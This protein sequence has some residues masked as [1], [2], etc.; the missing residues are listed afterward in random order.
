MVLEIVSVVE[1]YQRKIHNLKIK[2]GMKRAIEE[3]YNPEKNLKNRHLHS[4]RQKKEIPI[5]E[6]VRLRQLGLTFYDIALTLK[7]MG[8]DVSKATVHRRYQQYEKENK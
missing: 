3:G 4:G 1:K 8:F 2:R 6:I 7:G 5:E